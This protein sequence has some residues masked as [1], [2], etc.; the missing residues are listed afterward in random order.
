MQEPS[1]VSESSPTVAAPWGVYP[2]ART[3]RVM[4]GGVAV[5]GDAPVVVQSMC[6]TDTRDVAATVAQIHEMEE[7]GCEIVRVAVPDIEA[8]EAI[9]KIRPQIQIPLVA[10][11]HFDWRLAILAAQK[12][13]DKLRINPGNI[14]GKK[15]IAEV[16]ACARD[17]S[18]PIRVGVNQG[19]I[20]KDLLDKY[21]G[22]NPDS[23][24]ESALRNVEIL[25]EHDFHDIILSLKSSNPGE[26][27]AAYRSVSQKCDYPLHLGV[28]EAGPVKTGTLKS[29][30]AMGTLL[31]EGIGDTIRVS[32]TG[33][34]AEEMEACYGILQALGLRR[35]GPELVSCPSCGRIEIDLMSLVEEVQRT[36]KHVHTP[37]KV[38]VMG[39]VVN[40]PGEARDADWGIF[41]GKGV[42]LLTRKGEI[43]ERYTDRDE[44]KAALTRVLLSAE[45]EVERPMAVSLS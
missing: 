27:I 20:E 31:A 37:V 30:V 1:T 41:G 40:G 42:Y 6:D 34:K 38:A 11:I 2:R 25:A 13:A 28:T 19:S 5:G 45:H 35:R 24:V 14:G 39:C 36:L 22:N 29:A 8:G 16:V 4:V 43:V 21:G 33:P 17:R 44:A 32:L 26:A 18:L 15:K 7:A 12:G 9:A 23:L 10:D 3:R